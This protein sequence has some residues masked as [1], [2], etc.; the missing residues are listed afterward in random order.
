MVIL[1]GS[2]R[3]E[4]WDSLSTARSRTQRNE[5]VVALVSSVR[6][7]SYIT[8]NVSFSHIF[9]MNLIRVSMYDCEAFHSR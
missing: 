5:L 8:L 9:S 3:V 1:L 7:V 4:V 2:K 6:F